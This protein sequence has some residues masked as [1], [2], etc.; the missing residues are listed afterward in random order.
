MRQPNCFFHHKAIEE[1]DVGVELTGKAVEGA[2]IEWNIDGRHTQGLEVDHVLRALG[3]AG[4]GHLPVLGEKQP[5]QGQHVAA[6][7]RGVGFRPDIADDQ[8]LGH[9]AV[10]LQIGGAS[11]AEVPGRRQKQAKGRDPIYAVRTWTWPGEDSVQ[12]NEVIKGGKDQRGREILDV[13]WST[14]DYV[15]FKHPSGISPHFSDDEQLAKQQRS[16]YSDIGPTLSKVNALRSGLT[17]KTES[18][19]REIARA[20]S[21]ALDGHIDNA[22]VI[23][24]AVR[25]RLLGLRSAKGRLQYQCSAFVLMVLVSLVIWGYGVIG[26][27]DNQ[28][29]LVML[30]QVALCGA[31]G[32]FLSISMTIRTLDID[33]DADWKVNAIAG[34][35]RIIIAL[36]G[37]VFVYFAVKSGLVLGSLNLFAHPEGVYTLAIASGFSET[38][39]PNIL[40]R[41]SDS[42]GKEE[43]DTRQH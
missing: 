6:G 39:V 4:K 2:V 27:L 18:I 16:A 34:A 7:G 36:I 25:E 11:L 12:L 23:L 20:V 9:Y 42:G 32:G 43:I 40:S 8:N 19:D 1:H 41:V 15:I 38:L 17:A 35:S 22:R 28:P 30:L 10:H 14:R 33:P 21:Q 5:D 24:D 26:H 13:Y 29:A 31:V 37:S 3:G